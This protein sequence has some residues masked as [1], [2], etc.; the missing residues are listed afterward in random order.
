M[1]PI[2]FLLLF[3]PLFCFAGDYELSTPIDIPNEGWNKVLQVSNGNTLLFHLRPNKRIE[4]FVF[5]KDRT[6]IAHTS[7]AGDK[8]DAAA[9]ERSQLHGI[10][11]I[12]NE[13]VLF[14][15]QAI[16]NK[17]TLIRL[18]IDPNTGLKIAEDA[19]IESK[20]FKNTIDFTVSRAGNGNGY[21]VFCMKDLEANYKEKLT[22]IL[23][24]EVHNKTNSIDVNINTEEYD[25]VEYVGTDMAP[26]GSVAVT[27]ECKNI[28]HYPDVL[29]RYLA[30]CYLPKGASQFST[31]LSKIPS[32][33]APYYS[34][35]TT[36]AFDKRF[37]IFL[38]NAIIAVYKHGLVEHEKVIYTPMMLSYNMYNVADMKHEYLYH[39]MANDYWKENTGSTDIIYPVPLKAYTNQYGLTTLVSEENDQN[40]IYNG[41]KTGKKL[42]GQITVTHITSEGKEVWSTIIPKTQFLN[43]NLTSYQLTMRNRKKN[44]FRRYD[45][46]SDWIYQ[47]ASFNVYNTKARTSYIILND[48]KT[49][50]NTTLS[51][52][53]DTMYTTENNSNSLLK[54][55]LVCYK[56]SKSKD[57]T[58]TL[59]FDNE[60]LN[61]EESFAGMVEGADYNAASNT[62]ACLLIH[63]TKDGLQ[64]K[65]GW[66]KLEE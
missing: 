18:R 37:N 3:F 63:R 59:L 43:D 5:G 47:F 8:I 54:S 9:I 51:D 24:D 66:A 25:Y 20:S 49:N 55:G 46:Y 22:L 61:L 40:F 14:I 4:V 6:Q 44:L 10:Y 26:D 30:V 42:I 58:K 64:T 2:I 35:Y 31:V 52:K 12:N 36:N 28:V 62:Y 65:I 45:K 15:S 7:I 29:D 57:I 11:E 1:K 48:L 32:N 23:Y 16:F 50:F 33:T 19:I 38:I 17:E 56:I 39:E 34:L 53:R 27:L 60:V 13:A 21:A 41:K